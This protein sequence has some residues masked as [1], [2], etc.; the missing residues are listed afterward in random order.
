MNNNRGYIGMKEAATLLNK[1]Y[2]TIRNIVRDLSPSEKKI[3]IK[4]DSNKVLILKSFLIERYDFKEPKTDNKDETIKEL[5]NI[6]KES[7]REK[8]SQIRT[9]QQNETLRLTNE[10][11][12]RGFTH[13]SIMKI[14]KIKES[15][16][17]KILD[18]GKK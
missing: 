8:D 1:S 14:L 15:D 9:Y 4:K 2:S 13:D 11:L 5:I 3:Y 10:L 7:Q 17:V 16:F 12:N 18:I 6:I